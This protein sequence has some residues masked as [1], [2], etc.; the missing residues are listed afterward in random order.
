MCSVIN[1]SKN[2]NFGWPLQPRALYENGLPL[3]TSFEFMWRRTG[4]VVKVAGGRSNA[5]AE[6]WV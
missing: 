2:K 5:A 4:I 6:S 1:K 3:V